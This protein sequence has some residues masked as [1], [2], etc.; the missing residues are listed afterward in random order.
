MTEV[1]DQCH[2]GAEDLY[3]ASE[4][5]GRLSQTVARHV[6]SPV[7]RLYLPLSGVFFKVR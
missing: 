3:L 6:F 1:E 5:T 4:G 7:G 2:F